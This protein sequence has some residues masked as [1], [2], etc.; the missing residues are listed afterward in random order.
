MDY[1]GTIG[2]H[3]T[4]VLNRG[5]RHTVSFNDG[6]LLRNSTSGRDR[7]YFSR[8][9]NVGNYPLPDENPATDGGGNG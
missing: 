4:P 1:D 5:S 7:T 3:Y 6:L 8:S 2:N 9:N